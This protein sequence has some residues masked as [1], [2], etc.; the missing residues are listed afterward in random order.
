MQ[1]GMGEAKHVQSS[2][3]FHQESNQDLPALNHM[4]ATGFSGQ[5]RIMFN[6]F[7]KNVEENRMQLKHL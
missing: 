2:T 6:V 7:R 1:S 3:I 5:G 4:Q